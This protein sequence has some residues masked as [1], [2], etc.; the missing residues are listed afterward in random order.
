MSSDRRPVELGRHGNGLEGIYEDLDTGLCLVFCPA[1]C[2]VGDQ[3]SSG[4]GK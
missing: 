4:V 3:E 2:L 1:T